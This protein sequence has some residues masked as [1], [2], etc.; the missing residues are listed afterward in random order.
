MAMSGNGYTLG[1]IR[2]YT[3]SVNQVHRTRLD[4]LRAIFYTLLKGPRVRKG[5]ISF[6]PDIVTVKPT[7]K[8]TLVSI[9]FHKTEAFPQ[10]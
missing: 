1:Q 5:I 4:T 6:N 7:I 3:G 9:N 2:Y 10:N 8:T